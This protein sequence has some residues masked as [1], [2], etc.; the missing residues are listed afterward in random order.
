MNDTE[1]YFIYQII[2]IL[3]KN[4]IEKKSLCKKLQCFNNIVQFKNVSSYHYNYYDQLLESTLFFG[5]LKSQ[6]FK[7]NT[8]YQWYTVQENKVC[9]KTRSS[10]QDARRPSGHF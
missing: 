1:C 4:I 10:A 5:K 6:H 3:E 8:I 2:L 7:L 9:K